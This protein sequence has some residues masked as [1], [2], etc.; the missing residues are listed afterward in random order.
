MRERLIKPAAEE[1]AR[2]IAIA[3]K[4]MRTAIFQAAAFATAG[5][6]LMVLLV[7]GRI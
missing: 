3:E 7:S 6:V 4:S 2:A 1:R 5:A